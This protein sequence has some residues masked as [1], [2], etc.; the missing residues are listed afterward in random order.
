MDGEQLTLDMLLD[1]SL[2]HLENQRAELERLQEEIDR[3]EENLRRIQQA[4]Y[5]H[6]FQ[7]A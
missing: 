1:D 2:E 6:I 3:L 4:G 5:S 7:S